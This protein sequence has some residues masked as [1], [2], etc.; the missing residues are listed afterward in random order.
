[1]Q[2]V[3]VLKVQAEPTIENE[4]K[5]SAMKILEQAKLLNINT[6]Q[7]FDGAAEF[8]KQVKKPIIITIFSAPGFRRVGFLVPG[9]MPMSCPGLTACCMT[10]WNAWILS[11]VLATMLVSMLSI[12]DSAVICSLIGLTSLY[13][14]LTATE[15]SV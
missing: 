9:M 8:T 6:A 15:S 1:M 2:E 13:L 5:S 7:D 3:K 12:T 14:V 4:Q 11:M 10:C